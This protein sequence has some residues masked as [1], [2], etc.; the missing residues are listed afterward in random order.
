MGMIFVHTTWLR[1]HLMLPDTPFV[2]QQK[3][4]LGGN[5]KVAL[6]HLPEGS[7]F[8]HTGR[9]TMQVMCTKYIITTS[10]PLSPRLLMVEFNHDSNVI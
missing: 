9:V 2:F 7:S 10:Y 8:L 5:V 4:L 3:L 6:F 1:E